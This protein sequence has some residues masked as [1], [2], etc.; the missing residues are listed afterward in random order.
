MQAKPTRFT[1]GVL[2]SLGHGNRRRYAGRDDWRTPRGLFLQL[3]AEFGFTL[4]AAAQ[5]HNTQCERFFT[6]E[7]DGL[8]QPWSG[9]VWCNPPY[10]SEVIGSWICKARA[11]VVMGRAELAAVLVPVRADV[12]WWHEHALSATEV[13]FIRGRIRFEGMKGTAPFASAVLVY[14]AGEVR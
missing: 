1:R 14:R 4:D 12:G 10:R 8:E 2:G 11:E 5:D 13:R 6:P 7:Q 3:H 9:R